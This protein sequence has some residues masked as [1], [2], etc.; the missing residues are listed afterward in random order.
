[1][2]DDSLRAL[3]CLVEGEPFVFRVKPAGNT[4]IIDLRGLIKEERKNGVLSNVDAA[5]LTLW[6]V[7]TT[8][9]SDSTANSLL[10]V[11]L[12][13]PSGDD[14]RKG[15]IGKDVQGSV[16]LEDFNIISGYW[17]GTTPHNPKRLLQN[18]CG[19]SFW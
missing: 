12:A 9:A 16:K 13:P 2:A 5:V 4:D 6:K 1:M 11:D 8:V 14:E 7:G 17:P 10:Q 19:V 3:L 15:L 18:Y